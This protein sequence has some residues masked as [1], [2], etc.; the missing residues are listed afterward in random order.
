MP[1]ASELKEE[2]GA[3]AA[4]PGGAVNEID[5]ILAEFGEQTRAQL[6]L[7]AVRM[8]ALACFAGHTHDQ[9]AAVNDLDPEPWTDEDDDEDDDFLTE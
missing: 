3:G 1:P 9:E 2:P 8:Q 5:Q 4:T 6:E 7:E